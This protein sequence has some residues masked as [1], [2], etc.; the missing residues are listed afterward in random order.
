M[1]RYALVATMAS[2][3]PRLGSVYAS[4]ASLVTPVST[5]ALVK[6]TAPTARAVRKAIGASLVLAHAQDPLIV[7][8]YTLALPLPLAS[9]VCMS[10]ESHS[11]FRV[12]WCR[13]LGVPRRARTM[14]CARTR[15]RVFVTPAST[16][17]HAKAVRC[18]Y[19]PLPDVMLLV[20]R[21]CT[22]TCG[23]CCGVAACLFP[24]RVVFRAACPSSTADPCS[25]HSATGTCDAMGHCVCV[26]GWSGALCDQ[27]SWCSLLVV[28]V[29][30]VCVSTNVVRRAECFFPFPSSTAI[31]FFC[32]CNTRNA[33]ALLP[34]PATTTGDAPR[35][36]CVFVTTV[37]RARRVKSCAQSQTTR[38]AAA[39]E[40]ATLS[41]SVNATGATTAPRASQSAQVARRPPVTS[42]VH[43]T[44]TGSVCARSGT[45]GTPARTNA[46][47]EPT[48]LAR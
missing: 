28:S 22:L 37:T 38:C 45:M 35:A 33:L 42:M 6:S 1:A 18:A 16:D 12:G 3:P 24:C 26:H 19:F 46:M 11:L 32:P 14:A 4:L 39:T 9:L 43:A 30:C 25:G 23:L 21:P 13:A 31:H 2:V 41:D 8:R 34:P 17:L 27:V 7:W 15:G 40:H 20:R 48:L 5:L 10:D 47:A 29:L 44:T 36:T